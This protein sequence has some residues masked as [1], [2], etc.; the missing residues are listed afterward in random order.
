MAKDKDTENTESVIIKKKDE[1]VFDFEQLC[2]IKGY[3]AVKRAVMAK[4]YKQSLLLSLEDWVTKLKEDKI[5][6]K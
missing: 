6:N 2:D 4:K 1:S 3:D 5:I